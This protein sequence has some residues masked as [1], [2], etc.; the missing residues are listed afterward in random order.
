MSEIPP[1]LF[2][3]FLVV[4]WQGLATLLSLLVGFKQLLTLYPPD[5][6]PVEAWHLASGRGPRAVRF[7]G[8]LYVGVGERGLHLSANVGFRSWCLW[9]VPCIPWGA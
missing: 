9:G 3:V 8:A 7:K 5:P 6:E 2:L 4:A 1:A